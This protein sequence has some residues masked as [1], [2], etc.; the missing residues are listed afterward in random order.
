MNQ[1]KIILFSWMYFFVKMIVGNIKEFKMYIRSIHLVAI[2]DHLHNS[3]VSSHGTSQ[4]VSD[5]PDFERIDK[6][7]DGIFEN[8]FFQ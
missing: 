7:R 3:D 6:N 5:I 2:H 8:V 1:M 4:N